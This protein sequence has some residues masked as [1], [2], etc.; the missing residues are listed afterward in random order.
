MIR[1]LF[2]IIFTTIILSVLAQ[3]N[4][5]SQME[6]VYRLSSNVFEVQCISVL[7]NFREQTQDR[8]NA[9]V[10]SVLKE[11]RGVMI[12]LPISAN[13][14]T[15]IFPEPIGNM[16]DEDNIFIEGKEYILFVTSTEL[17]DLFCLKQLVDNTESILELTGIEHKDEGI[18]NKLRELQRNEKVITHASLEGENDDKSLILTK[19]LEHY[20][21]GG[22]YISVNHGIE[23][24]RTIKFLRVTDF[25]YG[26]T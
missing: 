7:N 20:N 19:I 13:L 2:P 18:K 4:E 10:F 16:R 6:K 23:I 14:I 11:Y 8:Q 22:G 12:K 26:K 15:V 21:C 24:L 9:A 3:E 17:N 1:I 25:Q 5:L